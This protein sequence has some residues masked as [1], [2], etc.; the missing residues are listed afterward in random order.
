M[1][2]CKDLTGMI[3]GRLTVLYRAEDR[4]GKTGKK[5]VVWHCKCSCSNQT[6]VDVYATNLLSKRKPTMSCGCLKSE[7]S[8]I[9]K[10]KQNRYDL[11]SFE[12]GVGYDSNGREFY[13]DKEDYDLIRNY[14][15]IVHVNKRK[16]KDGTVEERVKVMANG[17][18]HNG[19]RKAV[20]LHRLVMGL[21]DTEYCNNQVD[22]WDRN[23]LNNQKSNL[24]ICT[25]QQNSANKGIRSCNTNGLIGVRFKNGK[26]T[27]RI[28]YNYEHIWLGAYDTQYEA[29]KA[30][31]DKAIELFGEFANL[32]DLSKLT[33]PS[34]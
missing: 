8:R 12:Y 6:E 30:Y 4:V 10:S 22:H 25:N 11:N 3:F 16:R 2:K 27:A 5:S 33:P 24:R 15:W 26:Y 7:I 32:N 13:F 9:Q 29:A 20:L 17:K 23:P 21:Y 34:I 19:K 14:C 28:G 1:G 31:N 18:Y